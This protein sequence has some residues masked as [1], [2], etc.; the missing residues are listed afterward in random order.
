MLMYGFDMF[1]IRSSA[2]VLVLQRK[3]DMKA[4]LCI[5][6]LVLSAAP[7]SVAQ[8]SDHSVWEGVF[9]E[10]QAARGREVY[11]GSCSFCHGNRLDGAADDPD[12]RSA[13]P[14]AR[15][16]FLRNWEGRSLAV[17]F[18]YTRTTMPEGNPGSLADQEY[19]DVIAY[20]LSVSR[21]PA[22]DNELQADSQSLAPVVIQQEQ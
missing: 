17:L 8:Q 2:S 11:E 9:S 12:M 6:V 14:L 3:L 10:A 16:K 22:G 19:I 7:A 21:L 5:F 13:P 15:A 1:V 18:E 20:M 4:V